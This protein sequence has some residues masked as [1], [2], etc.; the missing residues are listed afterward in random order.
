MTTT[1]H[2]PSEAELLAR[3]IQGSTDIS[4]KPT[5]VSYTASGHAINTASLFVRPNSY[6]SI[7]QRLNPNYIA[8][9]KVNTSVVSIFS[10]PF[11]SGTLQTFSPGNSNIQG[12]LGSFLVPAG[13]RLV[14]F[15]QPNQVGLPI[16]T[17]QTSTNANAQSIRVEPYFPATVFENLYS[18]ASATLPFGPSNLGPTLAGAVSSL[19]VPSPYFITVKESYSGLKG[20]PSSA[21]DN[22][23]R[24]VNVD[25]LAGTL[26]DNSQL[27]YYPS[28]KFNA[29]PSASLPSVAVS[30]APGYQITLYDQSNQQGN[31][32]TFQS[33]TTLTAPWVN[34]IRSMSIDAIVFHLYPLSGFSGTPQKF[35]PGSHNI[36]PS[37][38]LTVASLSILPTFK[39]T[40]SNRSPL[41]RWGAANTALATNLNVGLQP[42]DLIDLP[43][44]PLRDLAYHFPAQ[45]Y[46]PVTKK[47]SPKTYAAGNT[48]QFPAGTPYDPITPPQGIRDTC[49]HFY[50]LSLIAFFAGVGT[51]D[52]CYSIDKYTVEFVESGEVQ[53]L[54]YTPVTPTGNNCSNPTKGADFSALSDI[55]Y[56]AITTFNTPN[57]PN[58]TLV[59]ASNTLLYSQ[60]WI[61]A[62]NTPDECA[63]AYTVSWPDPSYCPRHLARFRMHTRCCRSFANVLEQQNAKAKKKTKLKPG[64]Y[65]STIPGVCPADADIEYTAIVYSES[66]KGDLTPNA[67][68]DAPLV[69]N[70]EGYIS[71]ILH[72]HAFVAGAAQN[73]TSAQYSAFIAALNFFNCDDS[74]LATVKSL[75]FKWDNA[76]KAAWLAHLGPKPPRPTHS[77]YLD[78][79]EWCKNAFTG[80]SINW[81][82]IIPLEPNPDTCYNPSCLASRYVDCSEQATSKSSDSYHAH[83]RYIPPYQATY[84]SLVAVEDTPTNWLLLSSAGFAAGLAVIALAQVA[85][86]QIRSQSSADA[87]PYH[88]MM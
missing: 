65:S 44:F 61:L 45:A 80:V 85:L 26:Y 54:S 29:A 3:L 39:V 11:F 83:N 5:K 47:W 50:T 87:M 53:D 64:Q 72:Q 21:W 12:T 31:S 18:G 20:F 6:T 51:G 78:Q 62:S 86:Q 25:I 30:P 81:G 14:L 56:S 4:T 88:Q 73:L 34:N 16:D 48:S 55:A 9:A 68:A 76:S 15:P 74:L 35:I 36:N 7:N 40:L 42:A 59:N 75:R 8:D 33:Y 22:R 19:A 43:G 32:A 28:G 23:I 70:R 71:K 69:Y 84:R 38:L 60:A 17:N 46:D 77:S 1:P 63:P 79:N 2:H 58:A 37:T 66:D 10:G 67:D 27:H 82:R 57:T 49:E 24:S 13:Y 41:C 52:Y